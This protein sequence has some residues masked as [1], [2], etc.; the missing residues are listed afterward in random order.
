MKQ[1][2]T[3]ILPLLLCLLLLIPTLTACGTSLIDTDGTWGELTWSYSRNSKTLT[4]SGKG[5]M[6]NFESIDAVVWKSVRKNVTEL[7]IEEGVTSIG[8]YAFYYFS[9]LT[10]VSLPESLTSIGKSAFSFCYELPTL[11]LPE[12]LT[13]VGD[14]AFLGCGSLGSIYLPTSVT[15]VGDSAFAYCHSMKRAMITAEQVE[16]GE[17]TFFQCTSLRHIFMRANASHAALDAEALSGTMLTP[18]GI[19]H[20]DDLLIPTILTIRYVKDGEQIDL[21][22]ETYGNGVTYSVKSPVIEGYTA[23]PA[24]VNGTGNGEDR[25]VTVTY[26]VISEEDKPKTAISSLSIF[27]TAIMA[28]ALLVIAVVLFFLIRTKPRKKKA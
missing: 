22:E 21:Y 27:G 15:R 20:T 26:S 14:A 10:A 3:R 24:T 2:L 13:E 1:I 7:K 8:D 17:K 23:S 16:L 4:V 12:S 5:E 18:G 28:G 25:E 19:T 6:P 9:A 11:T